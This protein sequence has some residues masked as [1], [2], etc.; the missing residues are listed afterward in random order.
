[1]T[2]RRIRKGLAPGLSLAVPQGVDGVSD[3]KADLSLGSESRQNQS[4]AGVRCSTLP[5]LGAQGGFLGVGCVCGGVRFLSVTPAAVVVT[6]V[7]TWL[8]GP[9]KKTLPLWDKVGVRV[10]HR[11][12]QGLVAYPGPRGTRLSQRRV[13]LQEDHGDGP[14][15]STSHLGG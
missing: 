10:W 15:E 3:P 12:G 11:G 4:L 2:S 7:P 13:P 5:A 9:N 14:A 1:M 8:P 6:H